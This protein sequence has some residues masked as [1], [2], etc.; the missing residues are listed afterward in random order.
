MK[1]LND[2]LTYW[3][4]M[5]VLGIPKDQ[6]VRLYRLIEKEE[7][8]TTKVGAIPLLDRAKIEEL[9]GPDA[10]VPKF[11]PHVAYISLN[12]LIGAKEAADILG[13]TTRTMR[14]LASRYVVDTVD[15]SHWG[16]HRLFSKRS[17]VSE[18]NKRNMIDQARKLKYTARYKNG[19]RA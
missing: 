14:N 3:M 8:P 18:V 15:L 11:P 17:V 2:C 5:D 4:A 16:G 12:N 19:E 6:N 9:A 13:V 7:I 1:T 10:D